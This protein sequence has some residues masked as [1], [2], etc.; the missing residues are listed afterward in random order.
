MEGLGVV[1]QTHIVSTVKDAAAAVL[2]AVGG[3]TLGQLVALAEAERVTRRRA[4]SWRKHP[5][6]FWEAWDAARTRG[7]GAYNAVCTGSWFRW[8]EFRD[9]LHEATPAT[10]GSW[11]APIYAQFVSAKA[12]GR[13]PADALLQVVARER[14]RQE[15]IAVSASWHCWDSGARLWEFS[16]SDGI[17]REVV[18]AALKDAWQDLLRLERRYRSDAGDAAAQMAMALAAREHLTGEQFASLGEAW[19]TAISHWPQE[20]TQHGA[21]RP[22]PTLPRVPVR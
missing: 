17:D 13:G 6:S 15:S 4:A 12:A 5:S 9:D 1:G 2:T 10:Y 16:R 3:L 20:A 22:A 14:S 18:D 21:R 19:L 8:E 7:R 11:S